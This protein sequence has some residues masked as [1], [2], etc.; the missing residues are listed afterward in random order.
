MKAAGI[1]SNIPLGLDSSIRYLREPASH[2]APT[3]I[4]TRLFARAF[5]LALPACDASNCVSLVILNDAHDSLTRSMFFFVYG[6]LPPASQLG[7]EPT[8]THDD[9]TTAMPTT[10][11]PYIVH[12]K[13]WR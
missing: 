2:E 13:T 10:N 12:A 4:R 11:R 7:I 5:D 9:L 8:H 6:V 1:R 3:T